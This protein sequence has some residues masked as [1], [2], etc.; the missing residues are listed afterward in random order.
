MLSEGAEG[1]G[2]NPGK[3]TSREN[4]LT[5][6]GSARLK[7]SNL[8][9]CLENAQVARGYSPVCVSSHL[10]FMNTALP[11]TALY[12]CNTHRSQSPSLEFKDLCQ[13]FAHC[14]LLRTLHMSPNVIVSI[15]TGTVCLRVPA[16]HLTHAN[17]PL[18]E[19]I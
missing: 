10:P 17:C 12:S 9:A 6:I 1:S 14:T 8:L 18:Q 11:N 13:F 4:N 3:Y 5:S 19:H 7:K 15:S 16:T 2:L